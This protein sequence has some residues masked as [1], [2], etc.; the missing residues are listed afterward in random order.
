MN[1]NGEKEQHV[2]LYT[3]TIAAVTS[4]SFMSLDRLRE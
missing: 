3:F 2:A 1:K 4:I